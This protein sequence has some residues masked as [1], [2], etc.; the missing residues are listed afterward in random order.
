MQNSYHITASPKEIQNWKGSQLRCLMLTSMKR[1]QLKELL[2]ELI[3]NGKGAP[4]TLNIPPDYKIYPQGFLDAREIELDKVRIPIAGS[5]DYCQQL[6]DWWLEK[7]AKTPVWDIACTAEIDGKPGLILVE[8]KAHI[9]EMKEQDELQAGED[10]PNRDKIIKALEEMNSAYSLKLS[11]QHDYQMSNRLAWSLKLASLGIPVVLIYLGF[12]NADE[13][14]NNKKD[15][16]LDSQDKW[17]KE[18]RSHSE[19]IGFDGWNSPL[20]ALADKDSPKIPPRKVY[21][22]IRSLDLQPG[23]MEMKITLQM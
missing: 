10:S 16:L 21:P 14:A 22:L 2:T 1:D 19:R 4:K 3:T 13:M 15:N 11:H 17:I 12:R 9:G 23:T 20:Q 18:V 5:P 8:A 7:H 6:F